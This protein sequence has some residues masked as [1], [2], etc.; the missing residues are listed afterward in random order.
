[1][2]LIEE[3]TTAH[4]P[5]SLVEELRGEANSCLLR[6]R[7]PDLPE[8]RY[9][10]V[11]AAP[12]LTFRSY[13]D[14]CLMTDSRGGRTTVGSP[15]KLVGELLTRYAC[16]ASPP[17]PFPLGGCFGFWGY[18]LGYFLESKLKR[19]A[20]DDLG[21]P[22]CC[23][24]FYDSLVVFDH[25]VSKTWIISTGV[26]ADG[27]RSVPQQESRLQFWR[28]RLLRDPACRTSPPGESCPS[29]FPPIKSNL[30]RKEFIRRVRRVQRYIR[31]G[32]VYQVNL[33][34]RLETSLRCSAWELFTR[35]CTVS[36]AAFCAWMD[37]GDLQLASSSP[38]L[39]LQL[40]GDLVRTRPIKGTRPR[41]G[42]P[43]ADA[44]LTRELTSSPKEA[45][46]L[47]MITDLLRN[48]LGKV[49]SFGTVTVPEL[50]R[51][52]RYAQVQHLVSTVEGRLRPG[53]S[54]LGAL[55]ACFPGGSITGAPKFRA[56]EIIGELEPTARGPYTGALGYLGFNQQ[57]QL[58]II[59][60]TAVCHGQTAWFHAGAGIV[61]DSD[62]AAEYEETLAKAA[63]F[64]ETLSGWD[65]GPVEVLPA[66]RA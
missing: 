24:G 13:G 12:F 56:M 50:M 18:D 52:E 21:L 61:A 4:T 65:G 31:A 3:I 66:L 59:I 26:Q 27:T 43:A 44:T 30:S 41:A 16:P 54:H 35:L 37:C 17:T 53:T 10:L 19:T 25:V 2:A 63:G 22:D 6:S 23:L 58:S 47:L 32:D 57:S 14:R 11:T 29:G 39:F 33:S 51:L 9:S 60:R 49:C 20:T 46:E 40:N 1:M 48:D 38:E 7:R 42:D 28:E 36:P 45:A 34:H 5:E 15:W 8:G 62:P 64:L 55:A